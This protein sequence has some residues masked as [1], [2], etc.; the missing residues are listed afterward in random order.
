MSV[1]MAGRILVP[2]RTCWGLARAHGFAA[3]QDGHYYRRFRDAVL[4]AERSIFILGWDITGVVDLAPDATAADGAPTRL[5]RLIAFVARRRPALRCYILTWDYGLLYTLER[6]PLSRWRFG[7]RMPRN[8]RF[9][10][11]DRHPVGA[12]HHQK[13]VVIDDTLAF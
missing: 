11:D 6:D 4:A 10:F 3:L 12:C 9:G 8:V 5:D 1:A 2:G 7:W 13:I